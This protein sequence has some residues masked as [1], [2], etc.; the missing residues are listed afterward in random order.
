MP[1]P[2]RDLN[3]QERTWIREI[4]NAHQLWSD[5]DFSATRV[6]GKCD[7]GECKTV[8]LDS[9]APQNPSLHGTRGYIGSIEI[10]TTNGFGI[11]VTLDQL[12]GKLSELFVNHVDL[13]DPGN[14]PFPEE[15][16]EL[17]H[18]VVPM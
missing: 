16:Q 15:W 12:D 4:L 5:V 11:T 10:R 3:A 13:H 8:Y 17:E 14:R 2:E 18:L 7:C 1:I 9:A 6:V